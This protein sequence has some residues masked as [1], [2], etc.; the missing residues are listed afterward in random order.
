MHNMMS[1]QK[2]YNFPSLLYIKNAFRLEKG[3]H[4]WFA[5]KKRGEEI[6]LSFQM[7]WSSELK[8]SLPVFTAVYFNPEVLGSQT[9]TNTS[10]STGK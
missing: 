8:T 5:G 9:T 1:I 2:H 4:E 10:T 6:D 3:T 7:T